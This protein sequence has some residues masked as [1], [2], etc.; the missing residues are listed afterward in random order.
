MEDLEQDASPEDI[1][2]SY[3]SGDK[4]KVRAGGLSL[5]P[6][7]HAARRPRRMRGVGAAASATPNER[8]PLPPPPAGPHRPRDGHALVPLPVGVVP[9]RAGDPAHQ[10]QAGGAVRHDRQQGVPVLPAVQ[11]DSRVPQ[12]VRHP[13]AAP[14]EPEQVRACGVRRQRQRG[15]AACSGGRA[16]CTRRLQRAH[17][18]THACPLLPPRP[19]C[20]RAAATARTARPAPTS[21]RCTWR[22]A[23][24]S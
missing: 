24:S 8:P 17:A 4:S 7:G 15:G 14:R 2:L 16:A 9:Q 6:A 18:R 3:V 20:R 19:R 21:C 22:R 1:M 10:P 11:A 13:Q 23:S 12:A 5:L